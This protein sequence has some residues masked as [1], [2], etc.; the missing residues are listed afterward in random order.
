[1]KP[2]KRKPKKR[3]K[4]KLL[5]TTQSKRLKIKKRQLKKKLMKRSKKETK[6]VVE[7]VVI[8]TSALLTSIATSLGKFDKDSQKEFL[9]KLRSDIDKLLAKYAFGGMTDGAVQVMNVQQSNLSSS[10]VNPTM[11]A[12]GGGI[13]ADGR[14]VLRTFNGVG[15]NKNKTYKLIKDDRDSDG[16]PYYTLIEDQSG[17]V[18]AQGDS[19]DE[20]NGY[21][22]LMSGKF[23]NGGG[24]DKLPA[25]L[26]KRLGNINNILKKYGGR[27]LTEQE[28]IRWNIDNQT[29]SGWQSGE[30]A[31]DLSGV[32]TYKNNPTRR[33]YHTIGD[34][35][36]DISY[37]IT[38]V[39]YDMRYADIQEILKS[40]GNKFAEGGNV[41][42]KIPV[43]KID[44]VVMHYDGRSFEL[45]KYPAYVGGSAKEWL[46]EYPLDLED[47]KA[48]VFEIAPDEAYDI[49]DEI[50]NAE[51]IEDL[52]YAISDFKYFQ[53]DNTY[54]QNWWG[55]VV[56][57]G[58]LTESGDAYE[59]ALVFVKIH[60]GGDVRGNYSELKAFEL[61]E[62]AEDFPLYYARL[63]YYIVTPKGTLTLDTEDMEGY[64]LIVVEDETGTYDEGDYVTLDELG[65]SFDLSEHELYAKGG[66]TEHGLRVG[67]RIWGE[68]KDLNQ[69]F[70]KN[71]DEWKTINLDKG[72]RFAKGGNVSSMLRNRRGM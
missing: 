47:A 14:I 1:L 3:L 27:P 49:E 26:K 34:A 5:K 25:N 57:W 37:K 63:S 60:E 23:A 11:F 54:N 51:S 22:N 13:M 72:Q 44:K 62:L 12:N 42:E 41:D 71:N 43:K 8:D 7:R 33:E 68:S 35:L 20:V 66:M 45:D 69:V 15:G 65:E 52:M 36:I 39:D 59:K 46:G 53:R 56:D 4:Q 67:D 61:D 31:F 10:S 2:L 18:M 19:F 40:K 24:V 32:D 55:G 70:V 48:L 50:N 16:K 58:S 6:V 30:S 9:I 17:N 28:A 21:A 29:E 64:S 38:G